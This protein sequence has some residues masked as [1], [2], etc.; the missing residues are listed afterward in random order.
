MQTRNNCNLRKSY[1]EASS[2]NPCNPLL[3]LETRSNIIYRMSVENI[4]V[5]D[6]YGKY[7]NEISA[8]VYYNRSYYMNNLATE[9]LSVSIY[10]RINVPDQ[11]N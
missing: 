5:I 9:R 7:I 11:S 6:L 1:Q 3:D 4:I 2:L 10:D 8:C